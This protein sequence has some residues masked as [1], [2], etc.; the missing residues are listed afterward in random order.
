M[1]KAIA[2]AVLFCLTQAAWA[3]E[4]NP[5]CEQGC[6]ESVQACTD[7]C[8]KTQPKAKHPDCKKACSAGEKP[9]L[10]ECKKSK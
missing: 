9:C 2:T 7:Y 8:I 10:D 1:L 6:K 5:A 4:G 3:A